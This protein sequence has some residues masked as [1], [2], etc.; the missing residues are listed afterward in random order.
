M[1]R[2]Q[3]TMK[4]LTRP[5]NSEPASPLSVGNGDFVDR[6]APKRPRLYRS[7]KLACRAAKSTLETLGHLSRRESATA[8]DFTIAY[9]INGNTFRTIVDCL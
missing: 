7:L 6:T 5:N 9:V 4:G 1:A 8:T 2:G 3:P